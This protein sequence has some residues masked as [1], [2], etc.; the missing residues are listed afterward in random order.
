MHAFTLEYRSSENHRDA[1]P[2]VSLGKLSSLFSAESIL[3]VEAEN[4][5]QRE[6]SFRVEQTQTE[7]RIIIS[8]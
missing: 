4:R 7:R 6:E 5:I 8:V 2:T 3:E 1:V